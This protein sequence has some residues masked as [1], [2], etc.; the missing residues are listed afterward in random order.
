H[1]PK[2]MDEYL[3]E[4]EERFQR[5]AHRATAPFLQAEDDKNTDVRKL[6]EPVGVIAIAF[7]KELALPEV[8]YELGYQDPKEMG[9]IIKS[10]RELI[11]SGLG[12]LAEGGHIKRESWEAI[13]GTSLFQRAA[14]ILDKGT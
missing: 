11:R 1:E 6:E 10:N 3:K 8:A 2:K 12:G 9:L 5:A 14:R 13:R 7:Q 4:D